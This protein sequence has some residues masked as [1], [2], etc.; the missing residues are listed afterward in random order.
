MC[1]RPSLAVLALIL[2]ASVST[3]DSWD[4]PETYEVSSPS[5]NFRLQIDPAGEK[6]ESSATAALYAVRAWLPD[7]RVWSIDLENPILP[8]FAYVSDSG[9]VVT[10]DDWFDIGL[11]PRCVVLYSAA[12]RHI[13][14]LSL[15]DIATQEEQARMMWET[16]ST[17][18]WRGRAAFSK[19]SRW[20]EIEL[21]AFEFSGDPTTLEIERPLLRNIR[22]DLESG[23]VSSVPPAA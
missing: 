20:F 9:R 15:S 7:R 10:L 17:K 12:G 5:G 22:I 16:F 18:E 4:P 19:D 23:E 11:G 13:R 3:A 2:I 6:N 1:S 21:R 8:A 14:S